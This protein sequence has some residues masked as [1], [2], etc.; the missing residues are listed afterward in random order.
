MVF[1]ANVDPT[2]RKP[3]YL[4]NHTCIHRERGKQGG[5]EGQRE[6]GREGEGER[7][8]HTFDVKMKVS[9]LV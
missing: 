1:P 7:G 9:T 8:P 4:D 5:R 3:K 6:K 2:L